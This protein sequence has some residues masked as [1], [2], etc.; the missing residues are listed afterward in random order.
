MLVKDVLAARGRQD[1]W[2]IAPDR[3]MKDMAAMLREKRIG[4]LLVLDADQALVGLVSERDLVAALAE[5]FEDFASLTVADIMTREVIVCR[6]EDE[7]MD[8][9]SV[10]TRHR[11]RHIPVVTDGRPIS[12]L[13][14][15]EFDL[16]CRE[17][18]ELASTDSLTG[19]ANRREF[20]SILETEINRHKRF[21][22]AFCLA[23][24]DIDH[25]KS[26][27]DTYGH[28]AGDEV[29]RGLSQLLKGALRT[30]DVVG[31]LGGEEF[32]I[33]LPNTEFVDGVKIC[34]RL[35]GLIRQTV[36]ETVA[37]PITFTVS[38]G[39]TMA[40]G[41][42]TTG[43][44]YLRRADALLYQAKA[45]GRDRVIGQVIDAEVESEGPVAK[46]LAN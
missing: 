11:I 2:S 42:I 27:N 32:A 17:L 44:D 39:L 45:A 21:R 10:M 43:R 33:L 38:F 14:I 41:S 9:L 36:V 34:E 1:L 5:R 26:V 29:L 15:R 30:Y 37:G 28:D 25:F 7:I 16:A 20:M 31:R 23:M 6:L 3:K 19:L 18:Q 40:Y 8:I 46:A 13:S 4:A 12:M 24:L 35:I 22:S